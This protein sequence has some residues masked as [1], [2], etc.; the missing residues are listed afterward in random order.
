MGMVQT[1]QVVINTEQPICS[2]CIAN[3]NGINV[4]K[5]CVESVISQ[6]SD[7]STEIIIHDDASSDNSVDFIKQH[8]PQVILIE[9]KTNVGFCVSNNRMAKIAKGQYILLLNNDATLFPDALD[10]FFKFAKSQPQEG[11]LGLPQYHMQSEE[12]ID[13]GS[14]LDIFLNPIPNTK[15]ENHQVAQII[16]ACLWIPN[17][18]WEELEGF[19]EWFYTNAEDM[20]ISCYARLAGYPVIALDSSGF[21]HWVGNSLGGGKVSKNRL[22]TTINRRS[23]SE[24][25]K[26]Y[27]MLLI[28]PLSW[29]T[30][31]FPLHMTLLMLEG[32]V[33]SI[34]KK[35]TNIWKKIYWH[36]FSEIW[37]NKKFIFEKRK[38]IQR[39]RK[40][41]KKEFF[42]PF[43]FMPHKLSLLLKHGIPEIR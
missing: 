31:I 36:C 27:V 21:K 13:R 9:S 14:Y 8:Y 19:P 32:I 3:Y 17:S 4:I 35:E 34:I 37:K 12:L 23:L 33:L 7:I 42:L 41:S 15:N 39:K 43:Q 18:L 6:N 10:S 5:D 16:G 20:Y 22:S 38:I 29:L 28:Y 40:I 30:I 24:R 11:I 26:T 1:K 25:N 2:I